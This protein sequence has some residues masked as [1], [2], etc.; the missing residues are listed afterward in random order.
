MLYRIIGIDR[1]KFNHWKKHLDVDP[2][3]KR[4]TEGDF[5]TYWA[6][7]WLTGHGQ[8]KLPKLGKQ[9][10]WR[11]I[12][13]ACDTMPMASLEKCAIAVGWHDE[14]LY[15]LRNGEKLKGPI[16]AYHYIHFQRILA[17]YREGNEK[18]RGRSGDLKSSKL[19]SK[20]A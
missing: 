11:E 19:T 7:Y 3:K 14:K 6:I 5:I 8:H 15:F 18:Y 20:V 1:D 9:S 4:F 13:E 10:A 2:K 12:F 17:S 16:E